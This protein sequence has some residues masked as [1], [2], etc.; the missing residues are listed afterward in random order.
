MEAS[1]GG[2][3]VDAQIIDGQVVGGIRYTR[4][5]WAAKCRQEVEDARWAALNSKLDAIL[6]L[7]RKP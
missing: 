1:D 3:I 5:Q 7:L 6:E 4:E 2:V